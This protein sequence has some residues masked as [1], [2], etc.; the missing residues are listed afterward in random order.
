MIEVTSQKVIEVIRDEICNP[1]LNV[2]FICDK[3]ESSDTTICKKVKEDFDTTT[4]KLIENIRLFKIFKYTYD[5]KYSIYKSAFYYGILN[6]DS[7]HNMINRRFDKNPC[8]IEYELVI[9][10]NRKENFYSYHE[11]FLINNLLL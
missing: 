3:L 6:R 8:Q 7:F 1:D 4:S 9:E 11:K 5:H 2:N 10:K